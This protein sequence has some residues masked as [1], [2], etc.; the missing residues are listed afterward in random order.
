MSV[1]DTTGG[2]EDAD[3]VCTVD[4]AQPA[5]SR[6]GDLWILGRHHLLCGDATR[7]DSFKHLLDGHRAQM[8]FTDPPYNVPIDGHASGLGD[9]RHREFAMASG[10]MSEAEFTAFLEK[11]FGRLVKHSIDGSIHFICMDW[12]HCFELLSAG[13]RTYAELKALCV[14]NKTNGGMGS[15][16][17][18]KHELVFVFKNGGAPHVNN[19]ELGRFGRNRT[20]VWDYA[21]MNTFGDGRL[22]D[23]ATHPTI[24]PVDMIADAIL[25]CSKRDALVL[26][27][28]GGSG[29]TVIAAEKTG[30][31]AAVMELDAAYVDVAIRRY[32]KITGERAIHGLTGKTF[33]DVELERAGENNSID[34]KDKDGGG[35]ADVN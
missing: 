13:R 14:W 29:T 22:E 31:R 24:K 20:N 18:S 28:F 11:I 6:P 8:I 27:C 4:R 21:G 35:N 2:G 10:E 9:V 23:L 30:R 17:R 33:A 12:R 32:E 5:V 15:L 25:D 3:E 26:D 16:Y 19:I 34:S 1:P 7:E